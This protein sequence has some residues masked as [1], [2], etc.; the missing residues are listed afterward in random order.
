MAYPYSCSLSL[1]IL[2]TLIM[3]GCQSSSHNQNPTFTAP[4]FTD[5]LTSPAPYH[6]STQTA[7]TENSV[8]QNRLTAMETQ[9]SNLQDQINE[10]HQQQISLTQLLTTQ[11]SRKIESNKIN[12]TSNT[13][14][15]AR[16][17]Y[18]AGLYSQVISLLRKADNTTTSN[19]QIQ[20][21]MWLLLQ[22]HFHLNNCE[23]VINIGQQLVNQYPNDTQAANAL[24][25]VGRCQQH[26]QQNDIARVTYHRLISNYP[27]SS[28]VIRAQQQLKH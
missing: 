21:R 2:S 18:S 5:S 24:Y 19:T 27:H 1:L 8:I 14:T 3:T 25:L 23:S 15:R 26:L 20:E 11:T 17:L 6:A 13:I 9:L 10:I 28:F 16:Q 22:S 12:T 4:A 7:T